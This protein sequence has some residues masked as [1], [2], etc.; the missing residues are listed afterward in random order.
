MLSDPAA[1]SRGAALLT[2]S[3]PLRELRALASLSSPLRYL[4][5][6]TPP[7]RAERMGS[8]R[9]PDQALSQEF[10]LRRVSACT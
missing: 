6:R 5:P 4:V 2:I 1:C 9:A 7:A 3:G 8:G 10:K